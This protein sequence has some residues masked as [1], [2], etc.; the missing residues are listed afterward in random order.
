MPAISWSDIYLTGIPD[1][2]RDHEKIFS[3]VNKLHDSFEAGSADDEVDTAI[4][5]LV[6][7][8][9][10]H[11]A[12]EESLLASIHYIN[13]KPHATAHT[14]L[15]AQ[16]N[17]YAENYKTNPE[18]F[19]MDDFIGFLVKWLQTHILI[20]DMAYLNSVRQLTIRV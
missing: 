9:N 8:V 12:R 3:L 11:F 19:D 4:I 2:D 1:I 5:Q 15:T 17:S 10:D 16:M 13:L 20:E 14:S 18:T 6:D 7:Y